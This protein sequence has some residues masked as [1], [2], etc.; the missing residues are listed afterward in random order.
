[1]PAL[2]RRRGCET[3]L[4]SAS[5]IS[6]LLLVSWRYWTMTPSYHIPAHTWRRATVYWRSKVLADIALQ[7]DLRKLQTAI[8]WY[9]ADEGDGM[10]GKCG[11]GDQFFVRLEGAG[12]KPV[13][14]ELPVD[15][16]PHVNLLNGNYGFY[17][18]RLLRA[19]GA[20]I[21][22]KSLYQKTWLTQ[23]ERDQLLEIIHGWRHSKDQART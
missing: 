14:L 17:A 2:K 20:M 23:K 5:V 19:L 13:D 10:T 21:T 3:G 4:L 6:L 16:C 15:G 1:M 8:S 12:S 22:D 9:H 18:P 11:E 7:D